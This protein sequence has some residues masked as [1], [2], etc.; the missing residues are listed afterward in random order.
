MLNVAPRVNC[1][2]LNEVDKPPL[3]IGSFTPLYTIYSNKEPDTGV[4]V[5]GVSSMI[6]NF[7]RPSLD[8]PI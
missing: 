2:Y 4:R 1:L 8:R 7:G 5:P 6:A 3:N